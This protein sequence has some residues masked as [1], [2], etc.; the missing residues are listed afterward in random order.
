MVPCLPPSFPSFTY[1][2]HHSPKNSTHPTNGRDMSGFK[3]SPSTSDSTKSSS[4][5]ISQVLYFLIAVTGALLGSLYITSLP[6]GIPRSEHQYQVQIF[7]RDPLI[8]YIQNFVS[9]E[10]IAYLLR[11]AYGCAISPLYVAY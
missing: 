3:M 11:V 5:N 2:T 9:S 1:V 8:L 6:S 4:R 10:E 7:S